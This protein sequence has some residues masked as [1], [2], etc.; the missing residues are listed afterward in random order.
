MVSYSKWRLP[1]LVALQR[2]L[3]HALYELT[4]RPEKDEFGLLHDVVEFV[5]RR[6]YELDG[7]D[8]MERILGEAI[9]PFNEPEHSEMADT[10]ISNWFWRAAVGGKEGREAPA[11]PP[12][13]SLC[14]DC[15]PSLQPK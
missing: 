11:D 4:K 1:E 9:R 10:C 2:T 7:K 8:A 5:G 6:I 3:G 15:P 13:F 14:F 12:Q